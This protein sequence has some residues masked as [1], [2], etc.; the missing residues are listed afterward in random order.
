VDDRARFL[1][2]SRKC[3][4]GRFDLINRRVGCVKLAGEIIETH[5]AIGGGDGGALSGTDCHCFQLITGERG[6]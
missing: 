1:G 6:R 2:A 4:S 5:V 3:D